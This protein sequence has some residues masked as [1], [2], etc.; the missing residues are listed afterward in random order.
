MYLHIC[1][2]GFF[3]WKLRE[4]IILI[5]LWVRMFE[6]ERI[7]HEVKKSEFWARGDC[8]AW[9]ILRNR[10]SRRDR[11][12]ERKRKTY[13]KELAYVI[14]EAEKSSSAVGKLET[15]DSQWDS[16][17]LSLKAWEPGESMVKVPVWKL[18]GWKSK[19]SQCLSLVWRQEKTHDPAQTARQEF[20]L[21]Y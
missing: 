14:L 3:L 11:G 15:Q 10:T 5:N 13:Y 8:S 21:T 12:R 4:E 20:S 7:I 2:C 6:S 1:I 17:R 16:S 9:N 18:A 19:K